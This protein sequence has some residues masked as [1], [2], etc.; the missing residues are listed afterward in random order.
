MKQFVGDEEIHPNSSTRH[1]CEL[2]VVAEDSAPKLTGGATLLKDAI[3]VGQRFHWTSLNDRSSTGIAIVKR[4]RSDQEEGVSPEIEDYAAQWIEAE[5]QSGTLE[6]QNFTVLL[7]TDGNS[8]LDGAQ[9]EIE[10]SGN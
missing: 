2:R 8:Y 7:G 1:V 6:H 10:I 9:V 5:G 4:V 3:R